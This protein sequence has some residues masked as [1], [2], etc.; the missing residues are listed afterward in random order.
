MLNL[1]TNVELFF[2]SYR[3]RKQFVKKAIT[4]LIMKRCQ[5]RGEENNVKFSYTNETETNKQTKKIYVSSQKS[6]LI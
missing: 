3:K 6:S 4:V 2:R 5:K 1:C